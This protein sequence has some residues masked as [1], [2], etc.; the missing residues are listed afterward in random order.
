MLK[1]AKGIFF[2]QVFFV[3]IVIPSSELRV[4]SIALVSCPVFFSSDTH[5]QTIPCANVS[6]ENVMIVYKL[7]CYCTLSSKVV[8]YRAGLHLGAVGEGEGGG[9]G[10]LIF[11]RELVKRIFVTFLSEL[12]IAPLPSSPFNN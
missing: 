12:I 1:L 5:Y 8:N 6:E 11:P 7:C 2:L 9:G 3:V 10:T 4:N